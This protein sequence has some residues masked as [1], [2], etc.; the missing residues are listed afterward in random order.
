MGPAV[1]AEGGWQSVDSVY[2]GMPES[3]EQILHPEKYTA[4]EAPVAVT[5]PADL[6]TRLG[7][8]WTVPLMDTFGEFQTGIWLREGG[9]ETAE[10]TDAAAGWGGDRLAVMKGPDGAWA[11]A[12]RPSGTPRRTPLP[13]RR[14]P[15]TALGK[16]GGV[17]KVLPGEGGKTRWVVVAND[18]KTLGR[19]A[20]VL[21]LAG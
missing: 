11:L 18:E 19:V 8:G 9:V 15:T 20:N 17:A 12:G 2:A 5:L 6:A 13:S 16:A 3:T 21:G 4:K 7:T 1:Q 14:R 10:A